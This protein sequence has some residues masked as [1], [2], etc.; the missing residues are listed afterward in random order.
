MMEQMTEMQKQ[1]DKC[2]TC[3]R[4]LPPGSPCNKFYD[5]ELGSV[6]VCMDCTMKATVLYVRQMFGKK[7]K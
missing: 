3:K 4:I 2:T 1:M 7:P 5:D 6:T